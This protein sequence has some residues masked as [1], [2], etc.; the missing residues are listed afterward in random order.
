[1]RKQNINDAVK[2]TQKMDAE[3][4]KKLMK[5]VVSI[6]NYNNLPCG[7]KCK[8]KGMKVCFPLVSEDEDERFIK[9]YQKHFSQTFIQDDDLFDDVINGY[10]DLFYEDSIPAAINLM[11]IIAPVYFN[12]QE[13]EISKKFYMILD[14]LLAKR[15]PVG[16]YY[17]GLRRYFLSDDPQMDKL[18]LIEE[19]TSYENTYAAQFFEDN[20]ID[21]MYDDEYCEQLLSDD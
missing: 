14:F 15:N 6:K 21:N 19:L 1:M 11:S 20:I 18:N 4:K 5:N 10:M 13:E 9:I 17:E 2:N 12:D 16:L 3:M 7:T 8:L